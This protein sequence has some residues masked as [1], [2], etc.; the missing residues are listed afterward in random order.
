MRREHR[1]NR[2]AWWMA[3]MVWAA[4]FLPAVAGAAGGMPPMMTM[5]MPTMPTAIACQAPIMQIDPTDPQSSRPLGV[6]MT[7]GMLSMMLGFGE[8][9]GPV[10]IYLMVQRP[11]G[12]RMFL[13]GQGQW[14]TYPPEIVPWRMNSA[15]AV[16]AQVFQTN[17]TPGVM[18]GM[19][20]AYVVVVPAGMD[21]MMF[22]LDH[23][24]YYMWCFTQALP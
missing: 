3:W 9:A 6:S 2:S 4:G 14:R 19:Y 16:N 21:P 12:Q 15:M 7:D 11:D 17:L 23:S 1:N 13:D 10:D 18:A 24:P 8:F 5:P 22:S 20:A